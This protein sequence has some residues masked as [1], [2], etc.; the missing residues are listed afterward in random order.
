MV[1]GTLI[2]IEFE[3][4]KR[5]LDSTHERRSIAM[6]KADLQSVKAAS[7][8]MFSLSDLMLEH[9][10][11]CAICNGTLTERRQELS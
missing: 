5:L 8:N 2:C 10:L 7:E 11:K 3:R 1:D 6:E 4:L 9:T